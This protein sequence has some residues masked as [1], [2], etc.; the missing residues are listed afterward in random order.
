[1]STTAPLF[2]NCRTKHLRPEEAT[3][4]PLND[5]LINRLWWVVHDHCALLVIDLGV[6]SG[7]SDQVDNPLLTLIL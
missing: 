5:L 1:M 7:V 6:Y 2:R 3:L 4:G